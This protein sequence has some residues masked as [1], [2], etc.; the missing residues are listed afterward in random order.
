MVLKQLKL[1]MKI[2]FLGEFK[3]NWG[4]NC[5]YADFNVSMQLDIYESNDSSLVWWFDT[6]LLYILILI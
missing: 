4:I 3:W 5:S 6:I 1:N 2:L